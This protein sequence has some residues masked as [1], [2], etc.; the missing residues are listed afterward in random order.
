MDPTYRWMT[1]TQ[2]AR[3]FQRDPSLIR[4][5]CYSGFVIENGWK[6]HRSPSGYWS[7]GIPLTM[8]VATPCKL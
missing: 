1:I 6:A 2:A 3:Y 5:W 4:R 8:D 7:I